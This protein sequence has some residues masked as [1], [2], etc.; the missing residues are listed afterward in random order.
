MFWPRTKIL[1][2]LR[3]HNNF[4]N[5]FGDTDL[6]TKPSEQDIPIPEYIQSDAE[7]MGKL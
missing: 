1:K 3:I 5:L 7:K 2:I 4:C 6:I